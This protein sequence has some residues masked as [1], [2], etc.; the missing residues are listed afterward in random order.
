M[1]NKS[2][3]DRSNEEQNRFLYPF[4]IINQSISAKFKGFGLNLKQSMATHTGGRG[5]R[6]QRQLLKTNYA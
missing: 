3:E 5:L 1:K 4:N 6:G 2:L